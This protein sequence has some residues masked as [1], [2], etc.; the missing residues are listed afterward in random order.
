MLEQLV[1]QFLYHPEPTARAAPP[2]AWVRGAKEVWMAADD[3]NQI[4]GLYWPP[5]DANR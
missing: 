1:R 5:P 2:P 3:G 4:H